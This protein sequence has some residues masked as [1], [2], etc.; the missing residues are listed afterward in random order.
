[1]ND[2]ERQNPARYHRQMLLPQIGEEGQR[3]LRQAHGL[4]VGCGALGCAI[5]DALARA[6]IGALT[7]IDRDLVDRTNLHRQILFDERDA[8]KGIPKAE[9][10]RARIARINRE[11]TVVAHVDDL[12]HRNAE[13]YIR[14]AEPDLI[15]DGLDNFATRY[16]LNDLAVKHG[17]P[18]IHGGAVGTCGTVLSILPHPACRTGESRSK[19]RWT[20]GQATPCLRCVFP[21]PP[22]PGRGPTCDTAGVLGP[23]VMMIAARQAAEAIKLITGDLDAVD[24]AL[25]SIDAWTGRLSRLDL[26]GAREAACPC[27]GGGEFAFLAGHGADATTLLCGI[28]A[29]QII[30]PPRSDAAASIAPAA[31][32]RRLAPHGAFTANRFLV[33][34]VLDAERGEDGNPLEI[35]VF[36][37]GRAIIRGTSRPD[38]ARSVY[39][40]Y[41][42]G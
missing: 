32:A 13:A 12:N 25:V 27:C 37:T 16:L 33:R 23:L 42:G 19:I 35:T 1:M 3:R 5:A 17:L 31:L 41:I 4:V 6:G 34:G 10:A 15:L 29:V 2:T 11:T 20:A 18:F 9:A 40:R 7:I 24:R 38:L 8:E 14:S 36:P 21:E 39:A 22:A 28:K 26:T 30:P